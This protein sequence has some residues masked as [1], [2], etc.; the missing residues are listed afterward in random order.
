MDSKQDCKL[1][2]FPTNTFSLL[3][4]R[5]ATDAS[6]ASVRLNLWLPTFMTSELQ[7]F[8]R[9]SWGRELHVHGDAL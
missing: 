3:A 5:P 6:V 1:D 9:T 2:G 7:N 4:Y 8:M